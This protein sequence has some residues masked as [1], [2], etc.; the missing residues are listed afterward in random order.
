VNGVPALVI[1]GRLD[2]IT[3]A[4]AG[5][6]LAAGC[7]GRAT[8][9]SRAPR[10]PRSCRAHCASRSCSRSSCVLKPA[11]SFAS[12]AAG[13]VRPSIAPAPA[14]SPPPAC[15]R[16]W[17]QSCSSGSPCLLS[18]RAWW[19]DLGAGTGRVTR[20]LKRRYRGAL[21][22]ALDLAPGMLREARRHQQWWR[23]FERVCADALR[24]AAR[25][26]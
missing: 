4:A 19:L 3:R 13:C 2:R 24:L 25:R 17:P 10:T 8:S 12:T 20:E 22:I 21:V 14:M 1:A 7:R 6:A 18:S 11:R 15:R 16:A 26:R 23:R 9:N 5:R